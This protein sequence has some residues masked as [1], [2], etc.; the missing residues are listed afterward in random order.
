MKVTVTFYAYLRDQVGRK[1]SFE[2]DM[3]EGANISQLFDELCQDQQIQK[4]L[5][6]ENQDIKSDISILKNGREIKF[7]AGMETK[8][9]NNDEIAIFP[10]V[11]GGN[12]T[13]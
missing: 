7:L 5:L 3:E 13:V 6:D 9:V 4:V 8:L 1:E 12:Q 11:A 2:L 10:V